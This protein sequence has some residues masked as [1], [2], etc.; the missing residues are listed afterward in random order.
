MPSGFMELGSQMRVLRD[1]MLKMLRQHVMT[2]GRDL[3]ESS[4][5]SF[6]TLG[7]Y[8]NMGELLKRLGQ[9]E[10][11][12]K[13]YR[14]A[15]ELAE[16]IVKEQPDS[17]LA[18]ANLAIILMAL[19]DMEL[20]LYGEARRARDI[21][22]EGQ[23]MRQEVADHPRS[24]GFP[25]L[26]NKVNLS[27]YEMRLG[28]AEMALG[29][30][31]AALGHFTK[32]VDL[33]K[34]WAEAMPKED[35]AH[36]YLAQGYQWLAIARWH[37]GDAASSREAFAD[38]VRVMEGLLKKNTGAFWYKADL[39]DILG[40]RGDAELAWGMPEQAEKT[41]QESLKN[42]Q[43]A[44]A[45]VP[46]HAEWQLTLALHHERMAIIAQRKGN[47]VSAKVDYEE[48]LRI[49]KELLEIEPNNA[50]WLGS[51]LRVKAHTGAVSIAVKQFEM[52]YRRR[53]RSI[54]LLLDAARACATGVALSKEPA[55]KQRYVERAVGALHAAVRAGYKD[56]IALKTDP[57]LA[58]LRK[59]PLF[60]SLLAGLPRH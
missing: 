4:A 56:S 53:P 3:E 50:R 42:L 1:D 5:S 28:K 14:L 54:P 2:M 39:A 16:K 49:R 30:P 32:C 10:E 9:G 12:L 34:S 15:H 45:R 6:G 11:A 47:L 26:E 7:A 55:V 31:K 35:Q 59:E 38:A 20:D 33:R 37:T 41:Y 36:N 48:A 18:R 51:A 17:D 13:Q 58:P 43:P 57:D 19:G 21:F 44:L 60:T 23:K 46:N 22:D 40:T 27:H 29:D 24:G 8:Q 25:E 52:L